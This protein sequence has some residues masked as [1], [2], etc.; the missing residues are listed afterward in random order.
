VSTVSEIRAALS[1]LTNEDLREVDAALRQQ[2]RARKVGVLYDDAYGVWTEEDQASAA[3]EVFI[4][5][6]RKEQGREPS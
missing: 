4:L 6:D 3:A 5:M 1:G 2:F